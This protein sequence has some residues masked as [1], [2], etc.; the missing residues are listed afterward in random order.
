M[1]ETTVPEGLNFEDK[2][3]GYH[4]PETHRLEDKV[5]SSGRKERQRYE[6]RFLQ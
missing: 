6:Q 2:E 1:S 4:I 5:R 3:Q